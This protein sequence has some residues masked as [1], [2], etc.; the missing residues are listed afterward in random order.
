MAKRLYVGNLPYTISEP[1]LRDLFSQAGSV[2]SATVIVDRDT[3]QGKGFA[4]VEMTSE[5]EA[6]KAIEMFNGHQMD[7]RAIVVNEA[8]PQED[9]DNRGSKNFGFK[10][11]SAPR[12]RRDRY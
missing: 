2:E 7:G 6:Q 4:F 3:K 11:G 9:R 12:P 1:Q 8:R 5:E 10:G